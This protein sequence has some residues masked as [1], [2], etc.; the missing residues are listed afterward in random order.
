[1]GEEMGV[2]GEQSS[3]AVAVCCLAFVILMRVRPQGVEGFRSEFAD[4]KLVFG[5]AVVIVGAAVRLGGRQKDFW[6]A[7]RFGG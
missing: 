4:T 7:L 1:M 3:A 2:R 6:P 5:A